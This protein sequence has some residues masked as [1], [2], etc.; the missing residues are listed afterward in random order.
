MYMKSFSFVIIFATLLVAVVGLG[1]S[2]DAY[3]QGTTGRSPQQQ[4]Q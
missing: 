1:G 4:Q 3:A 2:M